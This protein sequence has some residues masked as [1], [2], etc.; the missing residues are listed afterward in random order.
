MEDRKEKI[1]QPTLPEALGAYALLDP[2]RFHM[3]GHKGKGMG[4]F[5]RDGLVN[6]DVTE[7][8]C[9]DNLHHPTAAI[10]KAQKNM[11]ATYHAKASFL[12]VNGSTAAVQ[13]MILALGPDDKLLLCRDAHRCAVNGAAL[14]GL[15]VDYISPEYD[16]ATGLWGM[17]TPEAL[18]G[19]LAATSATA[20]LVTSPNYYGLCA[21]I[22]GLSRVAHAHNALLLV[23]GAHGAH[24]PFSSALP[25]GL[26]GYA[27]M[28]SHSQH[29]TMDALTQAASLHIGPCR[30]APETLQ[31]MLSMVE[32]S[33]PSYLLMSSLDWSVYMAK[34]QDWTGQV[35]RMNKLRKKLAAIPGIALL[36]ESIGAGVAD[37]DR[38]RLVLDVTGRGLTGYAA[39]AIL[40]S[41]GVF[42]EMA[43]RQRLVLITSP[44]DDPNWYVRLATALSTLPQQPVKKTIAHPD[45]VSIYQQTPRRA[46]SP[47]EAVFAPC[48]QIPLEQAVGRV[49][50][51]PTGVYP[52]GIA[53]TMPG[54]VFSPEAVTFL[55]SES[56]DGA[57]LFGVS[58][59]LVTIAADIHG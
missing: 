31:R 59:G 40:E 51:A 49:A 47:R 1:N 55:L 17:V 56:E 7:L 45:G 6:W 22:A 27:D 36:P 14:R 50:V 19:A 13:A 38:T 48:V 18:D 8:S 12:V 37:R 52:P 34:R 15:P 2:A 35:S 4:G 44:E 58:D 39:A 24:F 16:A 11:A 32:T 5:W 25:P 54:E 28:W 26:G 3:P 29:K 43:D 30:I 9:T 41:S 20:A 42:V 23:D 21:D 33:S 57:T 46:L 10:L 53:L